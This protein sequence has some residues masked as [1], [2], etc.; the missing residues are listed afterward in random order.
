MSGKPSAIWEAIIFTIRPLRELEKWWG[1]VDMTFIVIIG[2]TAGI[3][4]F[5]E[6]LR[7]L[8][9]ILAP[10]LIALL[11]L[12]A[13]VRLMRPMVT[14]KYIR[15]A[16]KGSTIK[17][18][19]VKLSRLFE[20]RGDEIR[21]ITFE[22]C[23]FSGPGFMAIISDSLELK[24]NHFRDVGVWAAEDIK[25]D[26]G[27]AYFLH[28]DF[29]Y[30]DFHNMAVVLP[31]NA[32]D[33]LK[34]SVGYQAM[35]NKN[36][37]DEPDKIKD[38]KVKLD[39]EDVEKATGMEVTTPTELSNVDVNV[40]AKGVKEATGFKSTQ[41]NRPVGLAAMTIVCSCGKPFGIATTGYKPDKATCP[42]CGKEHELS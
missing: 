15:Q 1:W 11:F 19:K 23:E 2:I 35:D 17:N 38:T 12:I 24:G 6:E 30:C 42:H 16:K 10:S 33:K 9:T 22:H 41:V 27:I 7:W 34:K 21:N 13:T 3:G 29:K 20:K 8:L 26:R 36:K 31:K 40:T 18:E 28:C 14:V 37:K 39:A 4:L 5:V 25:D 32:A